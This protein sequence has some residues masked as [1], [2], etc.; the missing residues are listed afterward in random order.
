MST[1]VA[2]VTGGNKG[3]GFT[4]VR[5]LCKQF[6]GDVYLTARDVGRGEEAVKALASEGLKSHFY[7]L[8]IN[9]L[10]NIKTAAAYFKEKYGGVDV[11]VNNAAIAFRDP[12]PYPFAVQAEETLKTNFFATRDMLTHFLPLIKAGGRVVNVSSMSCKSAIDKCSPEHQQ[13]FRSEDITEDELVGLMQRFVDKAKKGEHKEDGWPET[14]YGMSKVGLTSLSMIHARRISKERPNDGIL[15]NACCPGWVKTEMGGPDAIKTPDEGAVTPVYLALLPPGATE[16]H[17]KLIADKTVQSS[18]ASAGTTTPSAVRD[19]STKAAVVTG[20]NK[21][22]GYAIVR[23]LCKQ[24]Q[25]DVHLTARDVGRGEEAVKSLASEGL[26][27]HFWQLDINDPNSIK[28]AAAYFKDK[29]GGVDILVNNAGILF[30]DPNPNPFAVQ[31]EE[32][33]KTNFFATRDMLTHFLPL[34]K[35]GGRVVNVSS[36]IGASALNKCS[37]ELQ[38]RFRSEDITEDELVGLMQ[39]FVDKAKKGE[40]KEDG[41]PEMAYGVSKAGLTT[42]SMIHA[43]RVSKERSNDGLLINACCPGWVHTD[44][45]GSQ[46]PKTPDD[47]AITPV[48][49]ALLSPGATEPHGKY[50]SEKTVQPW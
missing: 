13:R 15:I 28:T 6:Q 45:G 21:G 4:I 18:A 43:R 20:S 50:V 44:M 5:A 31:A 12:N 39:R 24:F 46:A 48:Y 3:I 38:R 10:N 49:L 37:S 27:A 29:Y 14:G 32:T 30:R 22:I 25:G 33:L 2:V 26:T 35:A 36:M 42:L 11:L 41:W 16:P 19:M 9:D 7:Q 8:D 17:G 47:G 40:H 34:I 23:A 1:K